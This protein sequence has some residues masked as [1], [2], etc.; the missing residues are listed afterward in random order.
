MAL[1]FIPAPV[2]AG[3]SGTSHPYFLAS[4]PGLLDAWYSVVQNSIGY[5]LDRVASLI[6]L[7]SHQSLYF[8]HSEGIVRD[9]IITPSSEEIAKT[10]ILVM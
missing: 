4:L 9:N 3:H 2:I 8:R 1:T 10:I 7:D 6:C 5:F